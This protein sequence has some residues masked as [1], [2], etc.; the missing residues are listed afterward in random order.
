MAYQGVPATKLRA[1]SFHMS[2]NLSLQ[3]HSHLGL[4]VNTCSSFKTQFRLLLQ[5][6]F[7][8]SL[9]PQAWYHPLCSH[10]PICFYLITLIPVLKQSVSIQD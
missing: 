3:P 8:V 7:L 10:R 1:D 4:P 6:I 2:P 9:P 5:E